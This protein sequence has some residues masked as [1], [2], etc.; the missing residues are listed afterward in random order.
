M[1]G[2]GKTNQRFY[3][4]R[5]NTVNSAHRGLRD[6]QNLSSFCFPI[7][8]VGLALTLACASTL[9]TSESRVWGLS[10]VTSSW[11]P[12][13]H[14]SGTSPFTCHQ[15]FSKSSA[16]SEPGLAVYVEHSI[17]G[18]FVCLLRNTEGREHMKSKFHKAAIE[19]WRSFAGSLFV[20]GKALSGNTFGLRPLTLWWVSY[21]VAWRVMLSGA[22]REVARLPFVGAGTYL[23]SYPGVFWFAE[24]TFDPCCFCWCLLHGVFLA[25]VEFIWTQDP[26][27]LKSSQSQK[28]GSVPRAFSSLAHAS[29]INLSPRARSNR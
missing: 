24:W 17:A 5:H 21:C 25:C 3:R 2:D 9:L 19:Q 23:Y 29:L 26:E 7:N 15:T 6:L 16:G 1:F 10:K 14:G 11:T 20:S 22:S 28:S 27:V 12:A 13:Y 4:R 18:D 8:L